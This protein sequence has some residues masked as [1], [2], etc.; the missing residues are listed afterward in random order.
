V[1]RRRAEST[2]LGALRPDADEVTRS[3]SDVLGVRL[4][5]DAT[6]AVEKNTRP[7]DGGDVALGEGRSLV[8]TVVNVA[9]SPRV[10]GG[11]TAS[12]LY[13][14]EVSEG[15]VQKPLQKKSLQL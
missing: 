13:R 2:Y 6:S 9:L 1:V 11:G 15:A 12:E 8:S 3:I 5:D 7:V 14:S 10:N 4:A